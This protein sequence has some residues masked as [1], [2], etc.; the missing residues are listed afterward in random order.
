[1]NQRIHFQ[2]YERIITC[3]LNR[4]FKLNIKGMTFYFCQNKSESNCS[5][6]FLYGNLL[7][8]YCKSTLNT[9]HCVIEVRIKQ[10]LKRYLD[11]LYPHLLILGICL[12]TI[13]MNII[14]LPVS[15]SWM[16]LCY[17]LHIIWGIIILYN[18]FTGPLNVF[19]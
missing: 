16:C 14:F 7:L 15:H 17:Q 4:P 10:L 13:I 3:K 5:T 18:I 6:D 12:N 9:L 1:M 11:E 19:C 8:K 2:Y